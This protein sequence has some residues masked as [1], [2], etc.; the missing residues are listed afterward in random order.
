MFTI[1]YLL[2]TNVHLRNLASLVHS[3][4]SLFGTCMICWCPLIGRAECIIG[5]QEGP[6]FF[7]VARVDLRE[8]R[9]SLVE[10]P[11][12]KLTPIG[13]RAESNAAH[14]QASQSPGK[15]PALEEQVDT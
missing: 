6:K 7:A 11:T 9:S 5:R 1:T 15:G 8:P 10:R 14:P 4:D 2:Q 12:T 3:V 13:Q